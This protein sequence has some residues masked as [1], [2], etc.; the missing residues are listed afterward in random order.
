[1]SGLK[2]AKSDELPLQVVEFFF[3]H[4]LEIDQTI[5]RAFDAADQLVELEMNGLRVAVLRV[6]DKKNHEKGHDCHAGV[7]D[8]LPRVR[9]VEQGAGRGPGDDGRERGYECPGEPTS[10]A[11]FLAKL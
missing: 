6:L 4:L 8:E 9:V 3:R 2:P 10:A 1:V 11:S 5:A 7:D